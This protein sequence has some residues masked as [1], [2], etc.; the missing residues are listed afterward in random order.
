MRMGRFVRA[1]LA[2]I[3]VTFALAA[4]WHLVLFKGVYDH[5]GIFNRREP[6]IALG[7]LSMVVQAVVLAY[8]YPFFYRGGGAV[9][10]GLRFGAV[11]GAF[12]ASSAVLATAGKHEVSSLGTWLVLESAFYAIQ[13]AIVGPLIAGIYGKEAA[14]PS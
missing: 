1:A 5:L 2:Y 7:V 13:F 3:I 14:P 10:E 6:L 8:V 9:R 12:I 11:M 4:S